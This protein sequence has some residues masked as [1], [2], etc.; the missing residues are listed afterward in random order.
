MYSSKSFSRRFTNV[1]SPFTDSYALALPTIAT[2]GLKLKRLPAMMGA[3]AFVVLYV[4]LLLTNTD[5]M[6]T[7]DQ[8]V[9]NNVPR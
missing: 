6:L 5:K 8:L 7:A 2:C 3:L 4:T 1:F 9:C